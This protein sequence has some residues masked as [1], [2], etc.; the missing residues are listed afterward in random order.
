MLT[1]IGLG[2]Y[3]KTDVSEK[4]LA[5]IR[6][7]DHIFLETYTSRLMGTS[8]EELAAYYGKTV[9]LLGR[10]DVEQHP[11][12]LLNKAESQNVV[13]LCA[14]DPMISTTHADL[15]MR[16]ASR[17]IKD[18]DYSCSIHLKC[19]LRSFR[20]PELPVREVLFSALPAEKLVPDIIH[21]CHRAEPVSAI[22][23]AGVS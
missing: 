19:S 7:A 12:E 20:A 17:G 2:L 16:A 5:S 1:F 14:G 3:D 21:R 13:F 4:G 23:H 6:N 11:D 10:E 22:A 9:R 8:Y 18:S 15:R